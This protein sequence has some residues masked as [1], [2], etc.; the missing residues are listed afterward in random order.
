MILN[1][2]QG[3]PYEVFTQA[4]VTEKIEAA[5][6][7]SAETVKNEIKAEIEKKDAALKVT[8][9]ALDKANRDLADSKNTDPNYKALREA[10][11][12]AEL[13]AS[14]AVKDREDLVAKAVQGATAVFATKLKDGMLERLAGGNQ[15][16]LDKLKVHYEKTLN[17]MPATTDSELAARVEAAYKLSEDKINPGLL[18]QVIGSKPTSSGKSAG[19]D[20]GAQLGLTEATYKYGEGF[21]LSKDDIIK[22]T[23]KAK[24]NY[25]NVIDSNK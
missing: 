8:Q 7:T 18:N 13:L 24:S 17:T 14:N 1:D 11:E 21:G 16:L 4:E 15:A 5:T 23:K 12:A 9:E 22:Y 20:E 10:K 25:V 3:K 2:A 19:G 6:K